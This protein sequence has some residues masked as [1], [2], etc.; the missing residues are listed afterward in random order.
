MTT[1]AALPQGAQEQ[2][3][4]GSGNLVPCPLAPG[5]SHSGTGFRM[6]HYLWTV[7]WEPGCV[8]ASGLPGEEGGAAQ[9]GV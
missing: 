3:R 8:P 4:Q 2:D 7:T 6:F 1:W 9:G 5:G